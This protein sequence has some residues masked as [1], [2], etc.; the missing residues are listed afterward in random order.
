MNKL[1]AHWVGLIGGLIGY[2]LEAHWVGSLC[3]SWTMSFGMMR[4][5]HQLKM[6]NLEA[7]W[8]RLIGGLIGLLAW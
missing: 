2:T 3:K 6:S 7:H 8:V 1:E 4:F 5:V